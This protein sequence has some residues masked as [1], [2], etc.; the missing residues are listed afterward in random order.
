VVWRTLNGPRKLHA[1]QAGILTGTKEEPV[2]DQP[3]GPSLHDQIAAYV[4]AA[5]ARVRFELTDVD[6]LVRRS[7]YRTYSASYLF[8]GVSI[9]LLDAN[10]RTM[11]ARGGSSHESS[12]SLAD[13]IPL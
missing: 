13:D 12:W 5:I 8:D 3:R 2:V 6:P 7:V 1:L 11:H 9:R 10:A 4:E